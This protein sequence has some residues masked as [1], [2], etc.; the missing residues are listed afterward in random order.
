MVNEGVLIVAA[1]T[2]K[3]IEAN[4]A[5]AEI[6]GANLRRLVGRRFPHGF[7]E[8]GG[9]NVE[10]LLAAVRAN[11]RGA[12]V[13]AR[14][15]ASGCEL[16]VAA[17]LLRQHDASHIL[18]LVRPSGSEAA[19]HLAPTARG[20]NTEPMLTARIGSSPLASSQRPIQPVLT[21]VLG[22]ADLWKMDWFVPGVMTQKK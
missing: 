22:D 12:S 21:G 18:V 20:G 7:D 13:R 8:Q 19:V 11:G 1:R 4:P 5:A 9:G 15:A 17:S 2:S 14:L 3:V 6:F 10:G 16:T